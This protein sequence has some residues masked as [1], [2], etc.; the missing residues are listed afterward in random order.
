MEVPANRGNPSAFEPAPGHEPSPGAVVTAERVGPDG[1]KN[2]I[3]KV[4]GRAFQVEVAAGGAI[5]SVQPSSVADVF[6]PRPASSGME[7]SVKAPMSGHILR[8]NVKEGQPV[9]AGQVVV[10]MEAMK[11]ETEVR[12]RNAGVVR[13]VCAKVGDPVAGNDVLVIVG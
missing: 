13:Q 5:S 3:V 8:I 1:I 2:Y 9:E 7:E 6:S 4:N 11:M 10:V 12:V